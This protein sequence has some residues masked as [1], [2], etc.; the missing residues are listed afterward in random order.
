MK[1]YLAFQ[2]CGRAYAYLNIFSVDNFTII[3]GQIVIPDRQF[4]R[5]RKMKS[6]DI[7][8]EVAIA[9]YRMTYFVYSKLLHGRNIK[10]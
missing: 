8:P 9:V 6:L 2:Q 10:K 7:Y 5:E 4:Q 1:L 3:I